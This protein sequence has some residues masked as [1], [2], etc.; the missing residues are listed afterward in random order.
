[1]G[2]KTAIELAV[3]VLQSLIVKA[4]VV[5]AVSSR[6]SLTQSFLSGRCSVVAHL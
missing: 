1:M 5:F 3:A 4:V 2:R 6:S